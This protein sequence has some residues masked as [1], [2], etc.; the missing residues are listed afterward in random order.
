MQ[1]QNRIF[2]DLSRI[3]NGAAGTFAGAAREFESVIRE[4]V[5]RFMAGQNFVSRDEFEA[6]KDMA[7]TARAEVE[8]LKA[9]LDAMTAAA[10]GADTGGA[11]AGARKRARKGAP[12]A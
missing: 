8:E 4:A 1:S 7:A 11:P 6:V 5:N 12:D 9:R 2:E 10:G 3:A